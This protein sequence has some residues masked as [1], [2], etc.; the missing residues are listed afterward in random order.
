MLKYGKSHFGLR[1]LNTLLRRYA[2]TNKKEFW[3]EK[4]MFESV[5][6]IEVD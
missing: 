6:G 2:K 3:V 5:V 4:R 1:F